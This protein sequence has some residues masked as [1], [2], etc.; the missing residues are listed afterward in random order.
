MCVA[1]IAKKGRR[2]SSSLVVHLSSS[3]VRQSSG[4]IRPRH[5]SFYLHELR[6]PHTYTRC[7]SLCYRLI[8]S[9]LVNL[10]TLSA[11]DAANQCRTIIVSVIIRRHITDLQDDTKAGPLCLLPIRINLHT[12][13]TQRHFILNTSVNFIVNYL[14]NM[15]IATWRAVTIHIF[16]LKFKQ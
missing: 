12:F 10:A 15:S 2:L 9:L 3:D 5:V 13:G 6:R 14:R 16:S 7:T 4:S 8:H 11:T 1:D